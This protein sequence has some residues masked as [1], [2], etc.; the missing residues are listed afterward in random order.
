MR[1]MSTASG[2]R[3][4]CA[5]LQRSGIALQVLIPAVRAP[6]SRRYYDWHWVVRFIPPL[7]P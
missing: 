2:V 1:A 5:R 6:G 7:T 4:E 3:N